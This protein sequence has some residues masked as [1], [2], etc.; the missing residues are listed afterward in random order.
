MA[1]APAPTVPLD[2][3]GRM[4]HPG[5]TQQTGGPST[6]ICGPCG[7]GRLPARSSGCTG[8]R[9]L[10]LAAG[11]DLRRS[12][13]VALKDGAALLWRDTLVLGRTGELP[14]RMVA[15]LGAG[16]RVL[17]TVAL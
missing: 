7:P 8:P 15:D 9:P 1:Q 3:L 10:T 17:D 14:G 13:R 16:A 6:V 5:L 2:P 11:C 12:T 4:A